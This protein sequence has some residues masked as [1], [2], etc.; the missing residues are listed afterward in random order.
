MLR[1]RAP[2]D[3]LAAQ[4]WTSPPLLIDTVIAVMCSVLFAIAVVTPG[5]I[6]P[7]VL[8]LPLPVSAWI[9]TAAC[10]RTAKVVELTPEA[11]RFWRH[12]GVA[13]ALI[14]VAS[15]VQIKDMLDGR[16]MLDVTPWAITPYGAAVAT[17]LWALFRLPVA[18]RSRA[19][20]IR[21][22]L[23]TCTV[24]VGT[25]LF[26]WHLWTRV[27][28][29]HRIPT[30]AMV[31]SIAVLVLAMVGVLALAKVALTG[32]AL[33]DRRA[34]RFLAIALLGSSAASST[35]PLLAGRPELS[36]A[37]FVVPFAALC[38]VAAAEWQRAAALVGDIRTASTRTRRPFS[39]LP[40]LAVAAVD[41]L[42]IGVA[43]YSGNHDGIGIVAG[44]VVIITGLVVMRQLTAMSENTHLLARLD[45]GLLKLSAH[46]RRFRSLVQ[47]AS[48][49]IAI[50]APDGTLSY[51]SPGVQRVL[52]TSAEGW[53][54]ASLWSA[55]HRDDQPLA[56]EQFA[57]IA[58]APEA[59]TAFQVRLAHADGSWRWTEVIGANL[60]HEPGV[61]GIVLNVRDVTEARE[62]QDR[63]SH[64]ATHDSLTG[65]ANRVLF[66]ERVKRSVSIADTEHRLSVVLIDLDNFKSVNDS[67][68][69]AIGDALLV[70]AAE[71][72]KGNVRPMDTV[73]RLGGDEFA[74]LLEG[75][76]P[77]EADTAVERIITALTEPLFALSYEMLIQA[78]F[79]IADGRAG[80]SGP[81][82]LRYADV[83]M[84]V[85]KAQG[86][87]RFMHY[88]PELETQSI[89]HAQLAAEL[90]QALESDQFRMVYQ[91]IVAIPGNR[92]SSVEALVRWQHPVRGL[93]A[94][95]DF[96]Q[97]AERSGL[98]LP[99]GRWVL[100]ESCHQAAAW[101]REHGDAAPGSISVNMSARQL[102]DPGLADDVARTLAE[103]GLLASQLVIEITETAAVGGGHTAQTLQSLHELGVRLALDDFGTGHSPIS[104]LQDCPVDQL[105]LDRSF[106]CESG[107]RNDTAAI[108]V[109]QLARA[110]GLDA[111]AEGVETAQQAEQLWR[112]GYRRAQGFHFGR[113]LSRDGVRELILGNI[114]RHDVGEEPTSRPLRSAAARRRRRAHGRGLSGPEAS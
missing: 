20:R 95:G 109:I 91:P 12:I 66:A 110:L 80:D 3:S 89:E 17:F 39:L 31:L 49:L 56:R 23:D 24:M 57:L 6:S 7:L 96:I 11:R 27:M 45:A 34:L 18:A 77:A 81:E 19:E 86:D 46:E 85:A 4:L 59:T 113:P 74:I 105:K 78:S 63:L 35:G 58:A 104:L 48:D 25:G 72:L 33:L 83:A 1:R 87:G 15:A 101:R 9:A 26:M 13:V 102:R 65:L 22:W 70:A 41:G 42:L 108:A 43:M 29:S 47:N 76:N 40:Y 92:L 8:W 52:G 71:R 55:V 73:A 114:H 103:S 112:L 79:G 84:Y 69:H 44:G 67:L 5:A 94:P 99:L 10:L 54:G 50:A 30:F 32:A 90:R 88:S 51:I 21:V 60:Q 14:G 93:V 97:A 75:M 82:L 107:A 98:I 38:V 2:G 62:F 68:G 37:I 64:E 28:L 36:D 100:R 16:P 53:D 111:V 106:V 61:Q